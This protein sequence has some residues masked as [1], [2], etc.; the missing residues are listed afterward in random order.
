MGRVPA[1]WAEDNQE[2]STTIEAFVDKVNNMVWDINQQ[3]LMI[4]W[5]VHS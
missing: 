1:V 5:T 3:D 2:A 4:C